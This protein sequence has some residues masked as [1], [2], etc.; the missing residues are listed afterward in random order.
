MIVHGFNLRVINA[1]SPTETGGSD[2]MKD[3]F[4]RLLKKA[5]VKREKHQK[6]IVLGDFNAK[7][8]VA[9]KHC[10][11]DGVQFIEDE[12]CMQR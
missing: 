2:S 9:Y 1:Y 3:N 8:S 7:T 6:I 10:N 5:S 4:Y 11:F 12:D